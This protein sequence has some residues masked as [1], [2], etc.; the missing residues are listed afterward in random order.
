MTPADIVT[1]KWRKRLEMRSLPVNLQI[2]LEILADQFC[3]SYLKEARDT[4]SLVVTKP[5][6]VK[7]AAIFTKAKKEYGKINCN[8][9]CAVYKMCG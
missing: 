1:G 8:K 3:D 5:E 2:W 6:L 4:S 9:N 7:I